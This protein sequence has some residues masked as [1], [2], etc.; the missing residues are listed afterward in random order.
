MQDYFEIDDPIQFESDPIE[1]VIEQGI[2]WYQCPYCPLKKK[3]KGELKIHVRIHTGE[4]PYAC[5]ICGKTF[6]RRYH[7][8]DHMLNKHDIVMEKGKPGRPAGEHPYVCSICGKSFYRRY[9]HKD[10]ML[11]E[12]NII[13]EKGKAGRPAFRK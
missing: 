5:S 10:H 7:H 12:H 11:N 6:N 3:N 9:L 4:H 8:R 2:K 13:V 1:L